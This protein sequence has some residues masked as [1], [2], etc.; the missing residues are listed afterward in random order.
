MIPVII[1]RAAPGAAETEARVQ[2]DGFRPVLS[3]TIKLFRDNS[4]ILQDIRLYS[5]LIFTSANGVRFFAEETDD[6]SLPAW[7]VGPATAQAAEKAGFLHVHESAGDAVDL[8]HFIAARQPQGLK[9]LL[10]IANSAAK[11]VV[12]NV[13]KTHQFDVDFQ[14]LYRTHT[15]DT[16][17]QAATD[18]LRS[19]E[20]VIVLVH[21]T[22]GAAGFAALSS[23]LPR[24]HLIGVAISEQAAAPL[25]EA[26]IAC[27]HIA[28]HPNEAGLMAALDQARATLSA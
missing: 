22:K 17:S 9:P 20:P 15:V 8:A 10:H 2:Q 6:R 21:S 7:C 24:D 23:D 4:V 19:E 12:K 11:L 27:P 26:G 5:G 25:L 13:L 1:T 28:A 18:C 3:S 16:L 14:P